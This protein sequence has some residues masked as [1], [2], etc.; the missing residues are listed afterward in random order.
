MVRRGLVLMSMA[1]LTACG[2]VPD[3]LRP[4]APAASAPSE[5][6]A[7]RPVAR[8]VTETALPLDGAQSVGALDT[9]SPEQKAAASAPAAVGAALG[10]TVASLG[11]PGEPGL[12]LKTPLV[13]RQGPGR[14]VY[15]ATG[16]SVAV[17]LIPIDAPPTAGSRMSLSAFQTLG[18]PLTGLPEVEVF[19]A[20]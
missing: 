17:T 3:T 4:N 12:W 11:D 6:A 13:T 20:G 14:V 16:A 5:T 10:R 2:I 1:A 18:A 19:R 7:Q 15:T 9:V 8:P